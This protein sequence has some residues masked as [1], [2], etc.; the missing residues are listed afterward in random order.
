MAKRYFHIHKYKRI[1]WGDNKTLV[2]RCMMENCAHYLHE[3]MVEGKRSVCWKCGKPFIMTKAHLMRVKPKC[4]AC[5]NY[6]AGPI[7]ELKLDELL[8]GI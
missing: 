8:K 7:G 3:P 2:W 6:K 1:E 5:V 4:D